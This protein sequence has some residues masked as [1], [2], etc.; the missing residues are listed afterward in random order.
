[1]AAST[2]KMNQLIK[3]REEIELEIKELNDVLHSVSLHTCY[4]I[5]P[6]KGCCHSC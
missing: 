6:S 1:M 5:F 3:K 2:D 4:F